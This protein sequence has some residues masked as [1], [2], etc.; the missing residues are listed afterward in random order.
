MQLP[1]STR[2]LP[3]AIGFAI[4]CLSAGFV[5]WQL[6]TDQHKA[7]LAAAML[8]MPVL[9]IISYKQSVNI[10]TT[11]APRERLQSYL[12]QYA[13]RWTPLGLLLG[14]VVVTFMYAYGLQN[15]LTWL[16][17]A[18]GDYFWVLQAGFVMLLLV[19]YLNAHS[20]TKIDR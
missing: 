6:P 3:P 20:M 14:Y 12:Q 2:L 16:Q 13:Q 7:M 9:L 8:V 5:C 4:G 11:L 15:S 17:T 1:L 10:D 18:T 19:R